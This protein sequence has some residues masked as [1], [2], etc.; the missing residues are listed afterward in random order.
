LRREPTLT[1]ALA[2]ALLGGNR[3]GRH[4]RLGEVV[5]DEGA[6]RSETDTDWAEGSTQLI[7]AEC[8]EAC[9]PWDESF[10]LYSE[11]ADFDLRARDA[12]FVTRFVPRAGA[13]HLEG[14]S[15]VSPRLWPLLMVNRVRLYRRRHGLVRAL[16]FWGAVVLREAS[17]AC[18]GKPTSRAALRALVS[19]ARLRQPAGPAWLR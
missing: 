2:D 6:Y 13:I 15:G 8:W 3:A 4:G 16:P 10:F 5:T 14:D 17:R 12:G 1:R 11:E 7:A 18:L 9:G 19:P